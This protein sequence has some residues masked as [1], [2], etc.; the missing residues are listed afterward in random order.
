MAAHDSFQPPLNLDPPPDPGAPFAPFHGPIS[1]RPRLIF[2]TELDGSALLNLLLRPH[3]LDMLAANDMGVAMALIDQDEQRVRAVRLMNQHKIYTA[4]WLMLPASEGLWF[5]LQNYPQAVEHYRAFHAWASEHE[6]HFEA[7]GIDIE[8]PLGSLASGP[9]WTFRELIV[10]LWQARENILYPAAHA[11]YSDLIAEMHHADYE[12]HAY[13]LPVVADD[14]RAGTTLLQRALDIVELP[15]DVEVLT[16]YSSLPFERLSNDFGGAL[17]ASYG[18]SSDGVAIGSTGGGATLDG[19]TETLPPL[20]WEALERDLLLAARHA[21]T[22]Y[23]F[24]LEGSVERGLLPRIV[25]LNWTADARPLLL[26]R[27]IVALFRGVVLVLLILLRFGRSVLA[28]SGWL[29][30]IVLLLRQAQRWL[31]RRYA[32]PVEKE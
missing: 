30:A 20:S 26:R 25:S 13:Q 22:I 2:F 19:D 8:P 4:A 24:S 7:V 1:N 14:R 3:V 27:I 5:N 28:W 17:V 16:C 32:D 15:A 23:I 12:V 6:L 31:R 10:R 9:Q 21:D 11:A 29:L 18:A